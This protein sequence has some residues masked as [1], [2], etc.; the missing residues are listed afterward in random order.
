VTR[1]ALIHPS[2]ECE[3]GAMIG[4]GTRI[5]RFS[6]VMAGARVGRCVSIGQGCF[7]A[8]SAV[9]GDSVRIQNGVSV[10]DGVTLQDFVFCGPGVAFTNVLV[11]RVEYPAQGHYLPTR[12]ETGASLG[13]N[14]TII[15]GVTVGQY[16]LVGA[17]SV[18]TRDVPD[19]AL[20]M[21][22]PARQTGWVSRR[23][24][25]LVFDR[26]GRADCPSGERYALVA[27][28]AAEGVM[29]N[30]VVRLLAPAP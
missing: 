9:I 29:A 18:V 5:W 8:G 20:V 6:H 13:A 21:G 2:A 26:D 15:A 22:N 11:P 19:F 14:A 27:G 12:V 10:F 16:A 23:G 28:A 1:D 24:A 30:S 25:A 17:G 4:E 3:P 7:V